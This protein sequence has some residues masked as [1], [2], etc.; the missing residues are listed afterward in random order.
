MET[1]KEQRPAGS[2]RTTCS[3]VG[4][5]HVEACDSKRLR[6]KV[7]PSMPYCRVCHG[8]ILASVGHSAG[9]PMA[10]MEDMTKEVERARRA[11]QWAKDRAEYWLIAVRQM[12][13][14]LAMLKAEVRKL[15]S[16]TNAGAVTPGE[17]G[18]ANE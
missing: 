2:S 4:D 9:C 18:K 13:G 8:K 10:T 5:A 17:K 12:H 6:T 15:R 1:P 14:K 3:S 11:E 16:R 7:V